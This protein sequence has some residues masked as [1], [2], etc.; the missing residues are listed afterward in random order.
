MAITYNG[1]KIDKIVYNGTAIFGGG[2]VA[3]DLLWSN[4]SPSSSFNSKTIVALNSDY[5]TKYKYL[6]IDYRTG[7]GSA[8]NKTSVGGT[9]ASIFI[10]GWSD[11]SAL[12]C[13][14]N[15]VLK[16]SYIECSNCYGFGSGTVVNNN[17]V[18]IKIYGI[19]DI[20]FGEGGA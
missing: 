8:S 20:T 18:P 3:V 12:N 16:D 10:G 7:S 11:D 14:R 2:K 15:I 6:R 9:A 4:P 19:K 13:V 17:C 5:R 1:T